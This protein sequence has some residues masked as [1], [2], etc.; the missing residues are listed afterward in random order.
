MI[1]IPSLVYFF[2]TTKIPESTNI[3]LYILIQFCFYGIISTILLF[4][5]NKIQ[6]G[7]ERHIF[8]NKRHAYWYFIPNMTYSII[9]IGL[10]SLLLINF[11]SISLLID[12]G[13]TI[14]NSIQYIN[15]PPHTNSNANT[16]IPPT[17]V[18]NSQIIP[19]LQPEIVKNI[20]DSVSPPPPTIDQQML[21][22]RVHEL[23]NQ[24][25]N[26]QSLSSL[27]YDPALVVIARKHSEDM[28]KNNYFEHVNLRGLDP[29][30]RSSQA[31]YSCYKNYG[32][33]YTTGIA[34]N[35]MQN[36]LYTSTTYYNGIPVHDW[37]TQEEIAQSTV[38]G[39]MDSAGHRKNILTSTY[40]R[41][42]IGVAISADDKVYITQ[43]FC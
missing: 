3:A 7:I 35:I 26:S 36:N 18:Q 27:S 32:S 5:C 14:A 12:N 16:P 34:E 8:K 31:G 25:R 1:T 4:I 23:I 39:W 30:G 38:N 24:Q 29:S 42:G 6:V 10:F 2:S 41:E 19:T 33:Y 17:T 13:A 9:G 11:G 22:R 28:A 15:E 37:S 21:E 40:D 20:Q 43:D